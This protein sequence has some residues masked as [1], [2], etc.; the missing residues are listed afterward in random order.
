MLDYT[1]TREV[2]LNTTVKV[3]V[4][5]IIIEYKDG[6]VVNYKE[7][8]KNNKEFDLDFGILLEFNFR[9]GWCNIQDKDTYAQMGRF[10]LDRKRDES[11]KRIELVFDD[12]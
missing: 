12:D 4:N 8:Y 7:L 10:S 5:N 2:S 9:H 11:I 3:S 1:I 6:S